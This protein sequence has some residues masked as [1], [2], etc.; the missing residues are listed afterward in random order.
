MA[1][2]PKCRLI[3][4]S[5]IS[6]SLVGTFP[7]QFMFQ[8]NKILKNMYAMYSKL[9]LGYFT[10][11]VFSQQLELLILI[12]DEEV[13]RNAIFA[14]I[15]VTPIY[16]ITLAK[17]LI[18]M[19]NSSFR[20]TIKQ[21][22]D[23]EKCKS[24]IEDDEV[25]EIELRIVQRSNK[26]VKYYGLMM[27]VLGTLFCVKPILMTPNIVSSGNTTKAIGFFPLSSWFPFDEQKHYPYAY[28]WQTLSLLQGTMY[29][30]TTDILMF[31]LIVF[32]AVQLRKLKHLLKN[33][34]HYKER[35]MTLYNIVDD[36]QAAKITLIYFIRRHKEII[37]YVR[38][39]NESMEIVMVFDF[40]QSS[41]HIASVLPE[42]LMSEISLMVVLTVASFLG[43]MLFR[44]SLYYYHANNVII[45]SAE[46]SYS[47]YESNW[48]DQTPK[49]KQMILIFMLR[50][51]EPLTLR[52]GGFAVM[53]IESL[54]AIL[55]ATYSYVMLMI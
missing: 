7:W 14:N 2:Y 52:I 16:T 24:P 29:V 42:V 37:E 50:T 40:L 39:F 54:I 47:I 19:L 3:Q 36:E 9:M 1:I 23:T 41:L 48:F 26:L 10:L 18:M 15:S 45:L 25:F 33:F 55:K 43:S 8:D 35:F 20:A 51:Q 17:Q 44:L 49:V 27:F 53:S 6:S 32:T 11:F 31:N 46:L 12:T 4:I 13:M 30:T 21:I 28:M 22:I 5:M 34:V 38:L